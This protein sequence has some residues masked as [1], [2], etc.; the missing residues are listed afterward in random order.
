[1]NEIKKNAPQILFMAVVTVLLYIGSAHQKLN[2]FFINDLFVS[3]SELEGCGREWEKSGLSEYLWQQDLSSEN[4]FR[5]PYA[6]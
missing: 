4:D 5:N 6:R 1:M 3:I 2:N